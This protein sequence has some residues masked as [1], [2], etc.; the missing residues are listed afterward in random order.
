MFQDA[1]KLE[2]YSQKLDAS[3]FVFGNHNKKRNEETSQAIP[4]I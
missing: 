2:F 1:T 3:L 4:A